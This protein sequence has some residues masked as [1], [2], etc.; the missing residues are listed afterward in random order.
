MIIEVPDIIPPAEELGSV[1]FVGVGGAALSGLAR[2]MVGRG[3]S[4]S[5][6]D[7]HDS[8]MLAS[9]RDLGIP[10]HVGHRADQVEG[11][12]TVVVSTAVREDN[13]EVVRA[14]ELG[15][16]V[17]PRSAAVQSLLLGRIAVVVTGTHGKTTTTSM[18][19]TA[20]I[21]CG[22]EPSYAI[23]STLNATGLNAAAGSGSIFVA[24][25]DESDEA[26]LTYTPTGAVVTNVD[27]DHLD[28]FGTVEAYVAVFDAFLDRID[29]GGFTV[30]CVDD[31]GAARLADLADKR[32]LKVVRVGESDQADLQ[33]RSA[34]FAGS[35]SA[36]EVWTGTRCLGTVTLQVPGAVY[37][38]DSLAAL[39]AGLELGYGFDELVVGLA[40]FRGSGRRME[41]K[42]RGGGVEVYDSYAHHPVEIAADLQAARAL[43]P[44]GKLV[45]CFQPHLV[46]RTRIFGERMGVALG[47]ADRVVVMEVYAAREDRDP[48]VDGGLVAS[49]VPLPRDHVAYEP[50][51]EAT[52]QRVVD[53]A[54]PGDVILT[55]GAGDV[56]EL[57]ADILAVLQVRDA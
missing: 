52:V 9:L 34:A 53:F 5:G 21:S 55:L 33:I 14:G 32:S 48:D 28:H 11:A 6:S 54:K 23:G 22:A 36:Y 39:A 42:G 38:M 8:A 24:E 19:A 20:L 16:R 27:A 2:I 1:H 56:T 12:D 44:A 50:D 3:L 18:L 41:H 35:T 15:L 13:A 45:V 40:S 49:A 57:G 25:G 26:I 29:P 10:C 51:R 43:V 47:G 30:C 17:W 37:V 46:S 31:P 4:V 7:I